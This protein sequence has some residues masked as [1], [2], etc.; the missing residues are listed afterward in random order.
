MA[1]ARVRLRVRI[2]VDLVLEDGADEHLVR[3]DPLGRWATAR[4]GALTRRRT[5]D[6]H[7]VIRRGKTSVPLDAADASA[8]HE[9][10][11]QLLAGWVLSLRRRDV[12]LEFHGETRV[13]DSELI[14][15]IER[16]SA[17]DA[18]RFAR[19]REHYEHAYPERIPVLPP[20]RA[21]DLVVLPAVGCPHAKCA[22]CSLHD[23]RRF[24]VFAEGEFLERLHHLA[25]WM[26]GSLRS[27]SGA[28]LGSASALSLSQE[29]LTR[30]L[31]HVREVLGQF[32]DGVAAFHDPDHAPRRDVTAFEELV[33][34]D[35][36]HVTIGLE[37]GDPAL[38]AALGK[39]KDLSRLRTAIAFQRVAGLRQA[40]T[41]LIG[42]GGLDARRTHRER[43]VEC[44]RT[45]ELT[46]RDRVFL[47]PLAGSLPPDV[48]TAEQRALRDELRN[49]TSAL[50]APYALDRFAHLA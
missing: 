48:M 3:L 24:R 31:T 18:E 47:S 7:V 26:G 29:R 16:A 23:D 32:Q 11:R 35:L 15:W 20:D 1:E 21:R 17:Y 42:A 4:F 50:V 38:R 19:E 28:F 6:G 33:A 12:E 36:R 43:T 5:L 30:V 10:V 8:I 39:S 2:G 40:V 46:A 34:H 41:I 27:R 13:T 14:E 45:L 49:V 44:V 22:F 37:S 25:R 9:R